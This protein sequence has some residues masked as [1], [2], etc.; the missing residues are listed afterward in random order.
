M[1]EADFVRRL[2]IN[3]TNQHHF[4][5]FVDNKYILKGEYLEDGFADIK[6]FETSQRYRYKVESLDHLDFLPNELKKGK[7]EKKIESSKNNPKR[8]LNILKQSR[9]T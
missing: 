8:S 6:Y 4:V 7:F 2:G 1:F 9:T 3:Y 5:R